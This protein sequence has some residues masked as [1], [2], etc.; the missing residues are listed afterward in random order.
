MS[1]KISPLPIAKN[2]WMKIFII[3]LYQKILSTLNHWTR[4][5]SAYGLEIDKLLL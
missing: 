1:K 5:N 2:Q 3:I 4:H